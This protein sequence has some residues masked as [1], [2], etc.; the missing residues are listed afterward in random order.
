MSIVAGLDGWKGGWVAITLAD[1]RF[2]DAFASPSLDEALP[3]LTSAE[4][5]GIDMPIGF[6]A[7]GTRRA[8]HG[9]DRTSRSRVA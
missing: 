4:V 7:S 5:I 1:G 8:D 9:R 3:R 6:P 2:Q